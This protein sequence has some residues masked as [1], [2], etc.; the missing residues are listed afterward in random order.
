[1]YDTDTNITILPP[2]TNK[3]V[4]KPI[5]FS[6][7][8]SRQNRQKFDCSFNIYI[9]H[10]V[11]TGKESGGPLNSHGHCGVD[12]GREGDVDQGHHHGNTA[13]QG[14]V[15]KYI[16]QKLLIITSDDNINLAV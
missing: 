11:D 9:I 2:A 7:C 15:L 12:A 4:I 3:H 1:M 14:H 5:Y 10:L 8:L 16:N 13:K 6:L